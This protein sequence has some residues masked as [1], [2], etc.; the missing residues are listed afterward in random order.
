MSTEDFDLDGYFR[1][2]GYGGAARPDF[3]TLSAIQALHVAAIP[4]EGLDPL[5]GRPVRLD[6][7]SLQAKLVRSRRGG[8]CFEHNI[9]LRAVLRA[10]GFQVT[11]LAARVLRSHVPGAPLPPRGHMVLRID[12][13]D[14]PRIADVGPGR[15]TPLRLDSLA[16]QKTPRTGTYQLAVDSGVYTLNVRQGDGW[17]PGLQFTLEPQEDSDYEVANWFYAAHPASPFTQRVIMFRLTEAAY[18]ELVDARL[19][20]RRRDGSVVERTLADA[21]EFGEVLDATFGIEPPAP[22]AEIFAKIAPG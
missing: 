1:R 3:E 20:E 2:I 8:Y 4:F 15:D 18:V 11:S 16:E 6:L 7:E 19:V 14:G 12:L 10:I 21:D 5:L 9:L 17:R 13:P 22:V